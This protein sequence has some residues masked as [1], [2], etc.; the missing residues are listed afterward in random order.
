MRISLC[1]DVVISHSTLRCNRAREH[2][3]AISAVVANVV[4]TDCR[5]NDNMVFTKDNLFYMYGGALRFLKCDVV[6]EGMEFRRNNGSSCIGGA[7]SLDSCSVVLDRAVFTD[8]IGVNGAGLYL[9]RSN[10]KECR[11]SNLL[12]D[13]NYS[14]HFGGGLEKTFKAVRSLENRPGSGMD[15]PSA[16]SAWS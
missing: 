5:I 10:H 6:M 2:G 7:I 12:F 14:V 8:N 4:M 11:L 1:D 9:M 16:I 3:G 15:E 13:H